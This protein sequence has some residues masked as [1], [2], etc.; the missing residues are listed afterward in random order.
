MSD[1]PAGDQAGETGASV[2][3]KSRT[4]HLTFEGEINNF[5]SVKEWAEEHCSPMVREITFENGE[6]LTEEGLPFLI[7]FHAPDDHDSVREFAQVV[8][9]RLPKERG[10]INFITADGHKF[11]HPLRHLGKTKKDLPV[12]A[13]DTFKHMY[14]FSPSTVKPLT[15]ATPP[16]ISAHPA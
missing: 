15:I 4:E 14:V 13:F 16:C 10:N 2:E 3:F 9:S 11:A 1:P 6:E 12:L 5:D 7:M 8:K